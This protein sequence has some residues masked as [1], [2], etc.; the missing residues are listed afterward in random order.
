MEYV[1]FELGFVEML[2]QRWKTLGVTGTAED[3]GEDARKEI[4]QGGIVR[5]VM[6]EAVKGM[7]A[8]QGLEHMLTF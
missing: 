8:S 3:E 4:L 5:A 2:R 7:W 6:E 1:K